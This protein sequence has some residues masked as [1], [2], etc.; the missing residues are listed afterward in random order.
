MNMKKALTTLVIA[1]AFAGYASAQTPTPKPSSTPP[2]ANNTARN[3]GDGKSPEGTADR[4]GNSDADL[5]LVQMIRKEIIADKSLSVGAKNCKVIVNEGTV[6]LRGPVES[7][8]EKETI[9]DIAVR[10]AGKNK[11]TDSL[12]VKMAAK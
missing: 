11:V 3:A 9:A 6:L 2:D 1:V 8:K 5:K 7:Q 10:A 12:E 4:Q